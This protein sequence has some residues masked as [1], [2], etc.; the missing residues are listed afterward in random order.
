MHAVQI[1]KTLQ[2][3]SDSDPMALFSQQISAE[4]AGFAAKSGLPPVDLLNHMFQLS[5]PFPF[6][7]FTTLSR[8][9]LQISGSMSKG[10]LGLCRD[11]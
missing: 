6:L 8:F 2:R 11:Q 4:P 9:I 1:E 3:T 10:P 7:Y 5:F